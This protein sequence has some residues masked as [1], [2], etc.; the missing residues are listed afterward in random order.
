MA[1]T[2][3]L[4][5][6]H[7][8]LRETWVSFLEQETDIELTGHSCSGQKALDMVKERLP[9]IVLLDIRMEPWNGLAALEALQQLK[10][11]L[12][13][14]ALSLY[15]QTEYLKKMLNMG[16]MGYL[17]KNCS[18]TELV[19]AIKEVSSG[20]KYLTDDVK[21]CIAGEGDSFAI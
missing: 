17:T 6:D 13:V 16:A 15:V 8:L 18:I 21:K 2:V 14:I 1:I 19:H 5:E 7:Q 20:N 3:F 11:G 4:I 9:D 10:A 12:K